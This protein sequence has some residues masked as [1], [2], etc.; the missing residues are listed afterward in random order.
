MNGKLKKFSGVLAAGAVAAALFAVPAA[1]AGGNSASSW[2][3]KGG[4]QWNGRV[5]IQAV[6]TDGGKHAKQGYH[7]FTRAAGPALDTG[8]LYTSVAPN[9]LDPTIR[10]REDYVIDSPFW[11]DSYTT[12]YSHNF[13]WFL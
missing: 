5:Q 4:V 10:A 11:G 7:R 9:K 13:I 6:V 12:K 8:R 2:E 1:A 3:S